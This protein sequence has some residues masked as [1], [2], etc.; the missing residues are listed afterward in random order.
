[1]AIQ[2]LSIEEIEQFAKREGVKEVAVFNFLSSCEG[3][4]VHAIANMRMDARVY[5]W[6]AATCEAIEAGLRF[7]N[8]KDIPAKTKKKYSRWVNKRVDR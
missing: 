8:R 7:A 4:Y 3:E 1:M 5:K 6:N 2:N